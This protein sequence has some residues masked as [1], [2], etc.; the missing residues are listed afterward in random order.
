MEDASSSSSKIASSWPMVAL[1]AAMVC[2][3]QGSKYLVNPS[4]WLLVL[5]YE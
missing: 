5:L 2:M 1:T 3:I 4:C